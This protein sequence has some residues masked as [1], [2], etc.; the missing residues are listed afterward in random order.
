[1]AF[2]FS[3]F[4]CCLREGMLTLNVV[5]CVI[6]FMSC[7][8][9]PVG[10]TLH[11][12]EVKLQPLRRSQPRGIN[13]HATRRDEMDSILLHHT[14][15][16]ICHQQVQRSE[17]SFSSNAISAA[18]LLQVRCIDQRANCSQPRFDSVSACRAAIERRTRKRIPLALQLGTPP[19]LLGL[20]QLGCETMKGGH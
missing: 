13:S 17:H 1:M 9:N 6:D 12:P 19:V 7:S 8:R 10:P 4:S 18:S 5:R 16:R 2:W 20:L 11:C 14:P 15:I 3:P